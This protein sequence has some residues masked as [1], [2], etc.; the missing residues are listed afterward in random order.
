MQID[1][2][3]HN[4]IFSEINLLIAV[5]I[6]SLLWFYTMRGGLG[7]LWGPFHKPI[8]NSQSESDKNVFCFLWKV[9]FNPVT[10]FAQVLMAYL[11]EDVLGYDVIGSL[12]LRL[13][14]KTYS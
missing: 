12:C 14:Q 11:L 4:N 13:E 2:K 3:A 10:I 7:G 9:R 8:V 5:C 6:V 1:V